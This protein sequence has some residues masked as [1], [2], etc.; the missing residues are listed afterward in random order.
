MI[1]RITIRRMDIGANLALIVLAFVVMNEG[2]KLGAG[3][4][5]SGPRPGFFP[6]SVA[7]IMAAGA[8]I[9]LIQAWRSNESRPFFEHRVEL[10]DLLKAGVPAAMAIAAIPLLGLY[11]TAAVY[12]MSFAWWHGGFRWYSAL[13]AGVLCAVSLYLILDW[14]FHIAMPKSPFYGKHIP[15]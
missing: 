14:G 10:I 4:G 5:P 12:V 2:D 7:S 8:L 11:L 9:A 3:W 15:I 13:A 6:F 1:E